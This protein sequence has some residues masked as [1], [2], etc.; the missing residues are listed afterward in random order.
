VVSRRAQATE[1]PRVKFATRNP[2]KLRE[3]REIL[4]P[5]GWTVDPLPK[6]FV[7]PQAEDLREV[8]RAKLAAVRDVPGWVLVEDS[9]LFLPG[10]GGFPGVYSAYVA[11]L[12]GGSRAFRPL[13]RALQG[14]PRTAIFR[15]V[16]GVSTGGRDRLFVGEIRGTIARQPQGSGG[17]GYD[18]IFCPDGERRTFAQMSAEEKN[19][20]SHRGR[21]LRKVGR[22]LARAGPTGPSRP[23]AYCRPT[24]PREA[25]DPGR[26]R[27]NGGVG[28]P[29]TRGRP[30]DRP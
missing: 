13:L 5:F 17:F 12:W 2:G 6:R 3:V 11:Q 25:G 23:E 28:S 1:R 7:E 10:L 4:A 20:F 18:P 22:F 8:V 9:G 26:R 21:A 15:T 27:V 19:R 24:R 30:G 14:A 16:A 29:G